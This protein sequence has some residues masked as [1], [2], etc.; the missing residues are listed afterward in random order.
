MPREQFHYDGSQ[1]LCDLIDEAG[2]RRRRE[3]RS[4]V[5]GFSRLLL[6]RSIGPADGRR[7][8]GCRS[9]RIRGRNLYGFAL[10]GNSLSG[11][12][13]LAYRTGFNMHGGVIRYAHPDELSD[14]RPSS[15][16]PAPSAPATSVTAPGSQPTGPV[17]QLHLF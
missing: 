5:R 14:K 6:G 11:E 3:P 15:V 8:S 12:V 7:I 9:Q 16:A 1:R 4:S 2:Q 17:T 13:K 10:W